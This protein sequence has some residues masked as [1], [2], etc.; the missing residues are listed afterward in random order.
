MAG[1]SNDDGVFIRS[2]AARGHLGGLAAAVPQAA[3]VLDAAGCDVILVETVGVGQSELEVATLVD[4]TIVVLAPG[5]GDGVQAVKAG[6]LEIADIYVVNK[7]DRAGADQTVR[8]LRAGRP[9]ATVPALAHG[10]SAPV[11]KTV[12]TT[13]QGVEDLVRS[14]ESHYQWLAQS[15]LRGERLRQ[16]AVDE[17]V[18]IAMAR[19]TTRMAD[20]KTTPEFKSLLDEVD[21]GRQDPYSA[22]DALCAELLG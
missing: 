6:I 22:A 14:I 5:M 20:L 17:V 21:A 2:I 3:R 7:A 1:H 15:G 16:R 19:L 13:G 8:D 18:A 11:V 10:W 12:A 4:T 9:R